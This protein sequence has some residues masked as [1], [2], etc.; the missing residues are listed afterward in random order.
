MFADGG[1]V[2]PTCDSVEGFFGAESV[3]W[4]VLS[5]SATALMTAQITNLLEADHLD[6]Q[7]PLIDHDP[8]SP[9]TGSAS[10]PLFPS[11]LGGR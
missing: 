7:N 4:R 6:F 5:D 8:L 1:F 3:A 11:A 2:E 9:P 10:A